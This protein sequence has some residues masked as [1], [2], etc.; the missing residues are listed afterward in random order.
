MSTVLDRDGQG[1][2]IRKA[3]IMGIVVKGGE[4]KPGDIIVVRLPPEPF[5]KLDRV[6]RPVPW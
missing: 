5:V 2:L 6:Q 4:V 3:G 1:A